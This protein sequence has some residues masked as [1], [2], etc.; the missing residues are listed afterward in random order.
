MGAS[1]SE[2]ARGPLGNKS[3]IARCFGSLEDWQGVR[4]AGVRAYGPYTTTRHG[5]WECTPRIL[6]IVIMVLGRHLIVGYLDP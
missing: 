1:R 3:P 2:G 6:G 5:P 4:H